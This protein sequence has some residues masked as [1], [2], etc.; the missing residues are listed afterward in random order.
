MI[1]ENFL[2]NLYFGYP[3]NGGLKSLEVF[4]PDEKALEIIDAYRSVS[5]EYPATYLEE[6]GRVPSELMD[7]LRQINFFGLNIPAVYGG[8]V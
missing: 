7:K 5:R 1:D 2:A 8:L 3:Q 4:H 6:Q